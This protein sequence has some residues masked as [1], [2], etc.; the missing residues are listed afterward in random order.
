MIKVGVIV[1][2]AS[3][4]VINCSSNRR[5]RLEILFVENAVLDASEVVKGRDYGLVLAHI[6]FARA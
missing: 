3:Q 4:I 5:V 1:F 2:V 6:D